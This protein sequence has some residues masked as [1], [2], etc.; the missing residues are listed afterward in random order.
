MK[1]LLLIVVYFVLMIVVVDL[2]IDL[3]IEIVLQL[4][5]IAMDYVS[6]SIFFC[7]RLVEQQ[8]DRAEQKVGTVSG[9]D[10]GQNMNDSLLPDNSLLLDNSA[11]RKILPRDEK[12]LQYVSQILLPNMNR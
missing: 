2:M 9:S 1:Q 4:F 3:L 11:A 10:V 5:L 12:A 8:E 7:L 6:S